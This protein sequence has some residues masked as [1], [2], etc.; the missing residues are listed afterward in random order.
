[1]TN[2][3]NMNNPVISLLRENFGIRKVSSTIKLT[4]KDNIY[5]TYRK[6]ADFIWKNGE[7]SQADY[8]T[9]IV[10]FATYTSLFDGLTIKPEDVVMVD[11]DEDS[12]IASNA[13]KIKRATEK[14]GSDIRVFFYKGTQTNDKNTID[15]FGYYAVDFANKLGTMNNSSYYLRSDSTVKWKVANAN[16]LIG[17]SLLA[18]NI[19]NAFCADL[20]VEESID[21]LQFVKSMKN[22]LRRLSL[23]TL[24]NYNWR[25]SGS[26][27]GEMTY[28]MLQSYANLSFN[29]WKKYRADYLSLSFIQTYINR[30]YNIV[31][32]EKY[33]RDIDKLS[34]TP[35][36]MQKKNI[37]EATRRVMRTTQLNHYF[38]SVELDNDVDLKLFSSFEPELMRLMELLPKPTD[39]LTLRLRKLGNYRASGLFVPSFQT[40]IIDFRTP[41]QIYSSLNDKDSLQQVGMAGYSSFIHEYGHYLDYNLS[42]EEPCLSLGNSFSQILS[43]YTEQVMKE[44][45]K[46]PSSGK[47]GIDYFTTA[48]EVFARS[49]ELYLWNKGLRSNLIGTEKEY[50]NKPEYLCFTTEIKNLIET[51]FDNLEAF[52]GMAN[53]FDTDVTAEPENKKSEAIVQ[54]WQPSSEQSSTNPD[55]DLVEH[56]VGENLTEYLLF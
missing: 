2:N 44:K 36:F 41:N 22:Q 46:F 30:T 40:L 52:K 45:D 17:Y 8:V 32:L 29:D 1:M 23:A 28:V 37:N 38:D 25:F 19:F 33:E 13:A 35:V 56:K 4:E 18:K 10:D 21:P 15:K 20:P 43:S 47:Y 49:F 42:Q 31:R 34:K 11:L 5:T 3:Q 54:L 50:L 16:R 14:S 6:I 39:N 55:Y 48:T 27:F 12:Q 9:A 24:R 7:W 51:Y 26:S 53:S